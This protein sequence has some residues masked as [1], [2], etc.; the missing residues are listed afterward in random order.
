MHLYHRSFG[1]GPPLILIHGL[2]GSSDNWVTFAKRLAE[3]FTI[4]LIDLPNHGRSPHTSEFSLDSLA[5]SVQE[6]ITEH[7]LKDLFLVGH[8][9]GG[10]VCLQVVLNKPSL[11]RAVAVLDIHFKAYPGGH[12]IILDAL[13]KMP[14]GEITSRQAADD[15]LSQRITESGIRQFLL[16]NLERTSDT[17]RWKMN[18]PV[19]DRHYYQVLKAIH[20]KHPVDTPSLFLRGERSTYVNE[21]DINTIYAIFNQASVETVAGA[22]HWLHVDAPDELFSHLLRFLNAQTK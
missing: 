7:N 10:K 22:G 20:F 2:F 9:L 16:K 8:S 14:L 5:E 11:V 13:L 19:I 17:F 3:Y 4:Y 12:E 18:L 1:A 6:F 21:E 15:W